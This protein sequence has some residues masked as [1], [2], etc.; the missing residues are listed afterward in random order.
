MDM[1]SVLGLGYGPISEDRLA[2]LEADGQIASY[3]ENGK[4]K[5]R[6][7]K[8]A[9]EKDNPFGGPERLRILWGKIAM[10]ANDFTKRYLERKRALSSGA[11]GEKR[12]SAASLLP[13]PAM[14][15]PARGTGL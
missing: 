7:V 1:N 6:R 13:R 9:Q 4:I 10:A 15:A 12:P 2:E 11:E 14:H 8:G 5:F 3:V